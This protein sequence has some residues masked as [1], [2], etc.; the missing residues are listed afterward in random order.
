MERVLVGMKK[1]ERGVDELRLHRN[2]SR[3]VLAF[4]VWNDDAIPVEF[5]NG[6]DDAK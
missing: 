6:L 5:P 2:L 3:D 4:H 1:G